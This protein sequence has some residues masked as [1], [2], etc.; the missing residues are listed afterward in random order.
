MTY[1][2]S[3]LFVCVSYL[4]LGLCYF[5]KRRKLILYLSLIAIIANGCS[6]MLLKAWTGVGVIAIA[7]LRNG[8][9]LL[10]S[11]IKVL[12]KYKI[13][14]WIILI[15]LLIVYGA[16]GVYTYDTI[17]SLFTIASSILYTVSIW[18]R[19]VTVYKVLGLISSACS[20]VYFAFIKSIFGLILEAV[21]FIVA[22]IAIAL[23]VKEKKKNKA[24]AIKSVSDVK[25]VAEQV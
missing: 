14:D 6:Y 10:Q 11:K 5:T 19:N 3:Q 13:D 22:I 1:W 9:F 18:Q 25:M 15:I 4:F 12:D 20:L 8:L 7:L 16:I 23:Y 17:F 21:M 2:L 24:S